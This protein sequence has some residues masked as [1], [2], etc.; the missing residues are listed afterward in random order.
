MSNS[1]VNLK[2]TQMKIPYRISIIWL[3]LGLGII[4]YTALKAIEYLFF[5]PPLPEKSFNEGVPLAAHIIYI[6]VIVLPLTMS[7]CS[8]FF[9]RKSFKVFSLIFGLLLALLHIFYF[10]KKVMGGFE[11]IS[12]IALLLFIAIVSIVLVSELNKWRKEL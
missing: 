5:H 4:A 11:N 7:I 6:L 12:I 9:N 1:H 8:L 2:S 10:V 3:V